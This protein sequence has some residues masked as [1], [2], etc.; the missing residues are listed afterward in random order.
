MREIYGEELYALI[1]RETNSHLLA[2][3]RVSWYLR[4]RFLR[5][6]FFGILF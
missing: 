5:R 3:C 6:N 4:W 2:I 1:R